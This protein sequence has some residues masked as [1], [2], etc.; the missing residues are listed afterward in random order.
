MTILTSSSATILMKKKIKSTVLE[1]HSLL[2]HVQNHDQNK[3]PDR[4]GFYDIGQL[5][6]PALHT[7]SAY[8]D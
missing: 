8:K 5:Q 1:N 7:F 3:E 4:I 2:R 6:P